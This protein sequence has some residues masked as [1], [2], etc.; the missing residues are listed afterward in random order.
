VT[1]GLAV[2]AALAALVAPSQAVQAQEAAGA[3]ILL[4]VGIDASL[5]D[6]RD[7][8]RL[9]IDEMQ[10][11]ASL[12]GRE[13]KAAWLSNRP[14]TATSPLAADEPASGLLVGTA[15]PLDAA[16]VA[17]SGVPVLAL[18][19]VNADSTAARSLWLFQLRAERPGTEWRPDLN[20]FGAGE[21]N[22][23]Y[24][25]RTGRGMTADA[26]VGWVAVKAVVEAALRGD[27]ATPDA[28]ATALRDL[29]FDGH[30]GVPLHF[31]ER[32]R[33]VQPTYD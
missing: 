13:V 28:L 11:T 25:R 18:S 2:I 17:G 26:W 20:R 1:R 19:P 33:L 4:V 14:P 16:A 8:V 5:T 23:R 30:K 29:E 22:E 21:L 6:M 12:L 27:A 32:Q 24:R 15:G 31:D 10:R 3:P 9:G 7:G